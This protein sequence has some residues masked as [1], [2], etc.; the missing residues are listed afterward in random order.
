MMTWTSTTSSADQPHF[1]HQPTQSNAQQHLEQC[2][3]LLDN[4]D[5]RFSFLSSVD[6]ILRNPILLPQFVSSSSFKSF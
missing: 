5:Y 4:F 3:I 2:D 1:Q 6:K